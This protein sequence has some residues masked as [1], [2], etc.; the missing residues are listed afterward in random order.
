MDLD[1]IYD[2]EIDELVPHELAIL[3]WPDERLTKPC[4]DI[5][6]FDDEDNKY[7]EQLVLDMT[8]TMLQNQGIGLA[9]PQVSIMAN[10][11]VLLVENKPVVLINPKIKSVSDE[12]YE[13]EEGC[14]SVPGYYEKR[15]R[16]RSVIVEFK[17]IFGND[18]E[19][20]FIGLWSFA[21]QHE[22]DHL[23]GKCFVDDL[24]KLKTSRVKKKIEK[25][26]KRK[27]PR[28]RG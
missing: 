2:R 10:V 1:A 4:Q 25:T 21:L 3:V 22:M 12:E 24:S 16:P 23:R 17:D 20:E 6:R 8:F 13:W 26:L 18:R 28:K 9:A 19:A 11:I 14:L 7:L 15:K 5:T 27:L